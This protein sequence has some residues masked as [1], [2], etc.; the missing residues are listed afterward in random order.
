MVSTS[1]DSS[2][3]SDNPSVP[4]S[5]RQVELSVQ[6]PGFYLNPLPKCLSSEKRDQDFLSE[7]KQ[8]VYC[9]DIASLLGKLDVTFCSSAKVAFVFGQQ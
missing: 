9:Q 2:S 4:Q 5:F 1:Q 7:D 3:D 8:F 6:P